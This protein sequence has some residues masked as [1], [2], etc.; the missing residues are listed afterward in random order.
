M[1]FEIDL[2]AVP[3]VVT[4]QDPDNFRGFKVVVKGAEHAYVSREALEQLAGERA[5]DPTW[6]ADLEKMLAY[7][8]EHG[9]VREDGA[10]RAH[11]EHES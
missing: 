7:A 2:S 1:Y 9:W 10:V 8:G 4:L 6:Q 5:Q 3:P 11:V